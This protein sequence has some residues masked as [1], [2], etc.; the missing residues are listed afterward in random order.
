MRNKT[1]GTFATVGNCC[2]KKFLGLPSDLIF[3]AIKRVR[4]DGNK[5]L[6][7]E[8]LEYARRMGW[9]NDLEA[10]FFLRIMCKRVMTDKQPA[11]KR[12]INAKFLLQMRHA[13]TRPATPA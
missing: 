11:K 10:D 7:A 8:A 3:E 13:R 5:S 6:N 4:A 1:N 2:V 9:I 12:Q